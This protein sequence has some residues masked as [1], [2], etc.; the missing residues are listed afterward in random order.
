MKNVF[1]ITLLALF[2]VGGLQ[3]QEVRFAGTAGYTLATAKI[4]IPEFGDESE[5]ESGFYFG[6]VA[7]FDLTES[8]EL[9]PELTYVNVD[10]TSFL[11]VP[12]L[13]KFGI[14]ESGFSLLAGPTVTYT[15]EDVD[16]VFTRFNIA[17]GAGVSYDITANLFAEARY[18]F[19]LNNYYTGDEVDDLTSRINFLNIGLGYRF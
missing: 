17:L 13:A 11:Q 9:R 4:D 1:K 14:A 2:V 16:D 10:D 12:I 18:A 3:A 5:S 15:L 6:L 7:E 8:I 19:Q